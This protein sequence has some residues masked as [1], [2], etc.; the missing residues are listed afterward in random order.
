MI[1]GFLLAAGLSALAVS[2]FTI[3]CKPP[4]LSSLTLTT[5]TSKCGASGDARDAPDGPHALQ[6][7]IKNNLCVRGK[8]APVTF[9]T[10]DRLQ[11]IVEDRDIASWSSNHLPEDRSIFRRLHKTTY[12]DVIGE[13]S[14]VRL[15]A[16]VGDVKRGGKE[17]VNC[18][19][20]RSG[21]VDYHIVLLPTPDADSCS[22]VTAEVIPHFRPVEW[23]AALIN[24]PDTPMRFTGQLFFDASHRPC[25][26]GVRLPG[27]PARFTVWEIHP[28]YAI[29][30]CRYVSIAKCRAND[31]SAWIPLTEWEGDDDLD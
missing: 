27:N 20:T 14:L 29:D 16:Y 3:P 8:P 26:G 15:V 18:K 12:G 2:Q 9:R 13:Q 31:N 6:N 22:S 10:F 24:T 7:A 1:C 23:D 4:F 17:S 19:Q 25:D 5:D 28:V 11:Q 30:V 21:Y